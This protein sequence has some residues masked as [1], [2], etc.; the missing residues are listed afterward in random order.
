VVTGANSGIGLE[1]ARSLAI[2]GADVVLAVRNA[3]KGSQAADDIQSTAPRATVT[4]G[5]LDLASLSSIEG[6]AKQLLAD[7]RPIDLLVNNAGIMAVPKRHT[8]EDGFE[9]QLGTNH[10]GHFALTGRLLPLLRAASGPR[11]TTVSSVAHRMGSI[12]FEDLDLER[13][14]RGWKAYSQSKLANL[15]FASELQRRSTREGWGILSNAAHPGSTRTNLQSTGPNMGTN[16]S[17]SFVDLPM[18]LPGMSQ[19]AV[20][21]ALPSLY[22]ATSPDAVGGEYY[23]PSGFME[24]TGTGVTT[25]TRSKRARSEADASRL[26]QVSETLTGVRYG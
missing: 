1:T 11:V 9:L 4:I 12:S 18:R 15:L 24:I 17:T 21:G 16:R 19:D 10:L 22:A 2:A 20:Q 5:A 6:F 14:Y 7:G 13:G 3:E 23:G 8:T 25:A 26:W